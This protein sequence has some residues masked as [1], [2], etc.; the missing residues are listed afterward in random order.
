MSL[1][2]TPLVVAAVL[3]A[4]APGLAQRAVRLQEYD[5]DAGGF[6]AR[7]PKRPE[8][9]TKE[10]ALGTGGHTVTVTTVKAEHEASKTVFA[11]TFADYPESYRQVPVKT[12]LDGVGSGLK[13]TDGKIERNEEVLLGDDKVPGREFRITAGKRV[14]QARVYLHGPRLYQV[15]VTGTIDKLPSDAVKEFLNSFELRK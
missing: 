12:V 5:S 8:S 2:L 14:I 10:L 3:V 7:F 4:A 9:D 15:M 11:V 1:R 6:R 13:G